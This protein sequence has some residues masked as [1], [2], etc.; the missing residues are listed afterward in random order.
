MADL[1]ED[2]TFPTEL[3]LFGWIFKGVENHNKVYLA[4]IKSYYKETHFN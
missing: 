2:P 1:C 3:L 4:Q